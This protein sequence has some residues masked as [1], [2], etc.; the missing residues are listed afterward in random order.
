MCVWDL[1]SE[2]L[3]LHAHAFPPLAQDGTGLPCGKLAL[4]LGGL[5]LSLEY[6]G[7]GWMVYTY[8]YACIS[9]ES[10]KYPSDF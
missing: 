2:K 1:V 7:V 9:K 5:W 3:L 4:W 8:Y 6:G 10:K